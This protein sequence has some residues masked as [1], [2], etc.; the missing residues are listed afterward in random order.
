MSFTR[1]SVQVLVMSES[2]KVIIMKVEGRKLLNAGLI[3]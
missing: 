2:M 3:F 1:T